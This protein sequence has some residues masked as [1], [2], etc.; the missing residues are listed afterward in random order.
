ERPGLVHVSEMSTEYV[1]DPSE[2]LKVDDEIDVVV[3]DIDRK[4]RQIRLSI[5]AADE[6]EEILDDEEE[7]EEPPTAMEI[8]LR[9]AMDDEP[10]S[11]DQERPDPSATKKSQEELEDILSR[12]L[13][14]RVKTSS[15]E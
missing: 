1:S 12:T 2:V 10:S 5:R 8:A 9:Q 15:S 13:K 11:K 14:Q 3:L 7:E 6:V 4:K